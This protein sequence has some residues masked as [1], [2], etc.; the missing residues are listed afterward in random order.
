M[1][2]GGGRV[3]EEGGSS[4]QTEGREGGGVERRVEER[5]LS[6]NITNIRSY[7][8]RPDTELSSCLYGAGLTVSTP[9]PGLGSGGGEV[10]QKEGREVVQK[11]VWEVV[12]K[13]GREVVQKEATRGLRGE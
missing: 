10:V 13:E 11:R 3:E 9:S 12:Q 8:F 2:E 5:S 7:K 4:G 1:E 6:R